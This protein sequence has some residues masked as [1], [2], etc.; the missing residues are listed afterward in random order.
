MTNNP[1]FSEWIANSRNHREDKDCLVKYIRGLK[2][3]VGRVIPAGTLA[4]DSKVYLD[5]MDEPLDST[6]YNH[7]HMVETLRHLY[8][9]IDDFKSNVSKFFDM[10]TEELGLANTERKGFDPYRYIGKCRTA[11]DQYARYLMGIGSNLAKHAAYTRDYY[12]NNYTIKPIDGLSLL[13]LR[14]DW[15]KM[16][17]MV[18]DYQSMQ[19]A[20]NTKSFLKKYG[21]SRVKH[22]KGEF[23]FYFE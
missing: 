4:T 5:L 17:T 22:C 3:N 20:M 10:F 18:N 9:Y 21:L 14:N 2:D 7:D 19:G 8:D 16:R 1:I 6:R 23:Y 12:E 13:V 15:D 11:L